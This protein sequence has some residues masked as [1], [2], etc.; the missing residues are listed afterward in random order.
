MRIEKRTFLRVFC[1]LLA[2]DAVAFSVVFVPRPA[3]KTE[4]WA[5]LDGQRPKPFIPGVPMDLGSC[6]DCLNFAV[7]RRGIGGWES[8]SANILQ[9][10]NLPAFLAATEVFSSRQRQAS[11][12]SKGHSDLATVVLVTIAALQCA[13]LAV[14][15]S[16]RFKRN[17]RAA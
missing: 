6:A 14:P 1:V 7:F 3:L 10:V 9:L 15:F 16:L 11:G 12:T 4:Q 2:L 13:L 5:F 17:P 8:A